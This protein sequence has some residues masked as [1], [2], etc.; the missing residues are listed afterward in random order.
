MDVCGVLVVY[1]YMYRCERN[2]Y[3]VLLRDDGYSISILLCGLIS[4]EFDAVSREK[5]DIL[6]AN[7][8]VSPVRSS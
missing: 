7:V 4:L 6:L 2:L 3:T 5:V 8:H 1:S